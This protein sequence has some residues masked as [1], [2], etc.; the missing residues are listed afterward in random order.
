MRAAFAACANGYLRSCIAWICWREELFNAVL[1][2]CAL[3]TAALKKTGE[4]A[5][6]QAAAQMARTTVER[7][8]EAAC[9]IRGFYTLR[10]AAPEKK[11]EV[12]VPSGANHA[13]DAIWAP[14]VQHPSYK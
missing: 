13:A 9:R 7:T 4:T 11:S 6:A 3:A 2:A 14:A 8:L 10:R 12:S 1:A 5:L